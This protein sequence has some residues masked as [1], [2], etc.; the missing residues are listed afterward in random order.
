MPPTSAAAPRS[1]LPA[2]VAVDWGTSSLRAWVL[3]PDGAPLAET[4]S[5]EGMDVVAAG[6]FEAVLRA[7]LGELGAAL[8]GL[9]RPLPVVLCGMVGARQGWREA[10]YL[11]VPVPLLEVADGAT[12]VAAE[13]LDARILPGLALRRPERHDVMRGEETQLLGLVL[14]EPEASG[15]VCMPG[16]HCKWVR[17][18]SGAVSDFTTV[19]TGELFALLSRDS[20]LRHTLAG[21]AA[22]GE[23]EAAGFRSGLAEG[24]AEPGLLGARLFSI[25]AG[26]L[27]AGIEGTE[28]ADRLS[29]LLIG[30]E[31]GAALAAAAPDGPI[32]LVASGRLARLYDAAIR[33]AGRE[34]RLVDADDAVR[35]GLIHAARRFWPLAEGDPAR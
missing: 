12:A 29:G 11:E 1:P 27:L 9:P 6:G 20:I 14:H 15:L 7:R 35:S 24:L 18:A 25:R 3:G 8:D 31:V 21:A 16:T 2:V 30:A 10:G 32:R 34:V 13:G 26:H 22:S 23:P 19:M 5:A 4:R 33:A 28:A 17:L